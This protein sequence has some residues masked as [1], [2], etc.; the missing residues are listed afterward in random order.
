MKNINRIVSLRLL[1]TASIILSVGCTNIGK[2][3]SLT[4]SEKITIDCDF[5]VKDYIEKPWGFKREG[6]SQA[7]LWVHH[8]I[9]GGLKYNKGKR[10]AALIEREYWSNSTKNKKI[11]SV[12]RIGSEKTSSGKSYLG[13]FD[14]PKKFTFIEVPENYLTRFN[15][16]KGSMSVKSLTCPVGIDKKT[17]SAKKKSLNSN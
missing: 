17:I 10:L 16:K 12:F 11:K 8:Q 6:I 13:I 7:L 14:Y 15:I 2:H 3:Q 4:N 1:F 9:K 5:N